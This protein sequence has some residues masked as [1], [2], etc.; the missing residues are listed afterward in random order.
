[1][2]ETMKAL[3]MYAPYDFRYEDVPIPEIG[4]DEILVKIEACGICAGDIKTY[5]E[6]IRV[7]GTS[8]KDRYIEAPVVGGHEFVGRV[9]ALGE[10]VKDYHIGER[11]IAEQL[12][13]CG[14][15]R[16]CRDGD[17]NMCQRHYIY[18]FK[19]DAQGGMAQYMRYR[20]DSILHRVPEE[21]SLE[22]AALIEPVACGMHCADRGKIQPEDVVV[23]SGLGVIGQ[24]IISVVKHQ[25]HAKTIIALD[26]RQ[27]RLDKALRQ[28]ADYAWNPL[29]CD[30][31]EKIKELTDGYG[32]D[33]YIEAAGSGA[34]VKQG[35]DAIRNRGRF[36]E[37]GVFPKVISADFN[38]IGDGKEID[39]YGSHL[40]PNCYERVIQAM[41]D[42]TINTD[43]LVS[44]QFPLSDW[45][46]AFETAEKDPD[47]F[48]VVLIP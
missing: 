14:E 38:V 11:L 23:V 32:C 2:S 4:P 20:K 27:S 22:Q 30:V 1:M 28:G 39:I 40:S 6:N 46:A 31:V 9:C 15:C 44:H 42:G 26:L 25:Y 18:G 16:Y 8:E 34:S 29:E 12:A 24:S 10:N 21:L 45:Q 7:W 17:Y 13:P 5:H 35:F 19:K 43:G 48:K 36:V 33:V 37:M 41:L 47:A 3:V